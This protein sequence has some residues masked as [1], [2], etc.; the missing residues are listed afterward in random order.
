VAL[1]S[2]RVRLAPLAGPV[3]KTVV[4]GRGAWS[5]RGEGHRN[6]VAKTLNSRPVHGFSCPFKQA[7]GALHRIA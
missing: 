2:R 3:A 7:S 5:T 4:I 6:G 1:I